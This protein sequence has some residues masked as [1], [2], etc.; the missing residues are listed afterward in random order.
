VEAARNIGE[1]DVRHQRGIVA[2]P[3]KPETFAHIAVDR[4]AH[5]IV[6]PMVV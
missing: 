4:H 3:I 6:V 2:E 5:V 1:V